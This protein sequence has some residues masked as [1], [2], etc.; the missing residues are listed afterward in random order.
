MKKRTWIILTVIIVIIGGTVGYFITRK[1]DP[2][3][4]VTVETAQ[5]RNLISTVSA[6]G[7]IEPVEQV[8]VSAEI[9]GRIIDL[10]V[11][12]GDRVEKGQFL[13]ALDRE[14]Y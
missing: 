13:V 8:K 14:T 10:A 9:P 5:V 7:T 11:K 6:T 4:E 2:R 1:K 12:E 3:T